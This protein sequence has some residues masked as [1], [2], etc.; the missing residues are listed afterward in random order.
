[1]M[2]NVGRRYVRYF[3]H[4]YQRSGTL[5]EGRFKSCVVY[6]E[7]YLLTCQRYIELNPERARMVKRPENDKWSSYHANGSGKRSSL[8]TPY[9]LWLRLGDSDLER[10]QS[11]RRLFAAHLDD[12]TVAEVRTAV[13]SGFALG[14]DRFKRE[15]ERL[16]GRRVRPLKPGPKKQS[17]PGENPREFLL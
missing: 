8:W 12:E 15:I 4:L 3:N 1:M 2:Q 13:N 10:A 16:T 14:K 9:P 5:W 11:Y 7:D 17:V 6:A